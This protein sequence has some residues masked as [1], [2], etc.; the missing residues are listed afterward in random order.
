MLEGGLTEGHHY[1]TDKKNY[2]RLKVAS[3]LGVGG[4]NSTHVCKTIK[5]V[6]YKVHK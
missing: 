2:E 3:F 6:H 5:N 4:P 1:F